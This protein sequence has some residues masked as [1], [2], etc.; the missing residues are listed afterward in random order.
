MATK[1]AAAKSSAAKT[2]KAQPKKAI[3][4][5]PATKKASPKKAAKKAATKGGGR[6]SAVSAIGRIARGVGHALEDV[7]KGAVEGVVAAVSPRSVLKRAKGSTSA[8]PKSE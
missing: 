1:K 4:K 6:A 7:A 3:A 5:K 8:K 2:K